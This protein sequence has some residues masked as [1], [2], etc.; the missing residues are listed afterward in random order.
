MIDSNDDHLCVKSGAD[1][2]GRHAA[3]PSENVLFED[4]EVR[5]VSSPSFWGYGVVPV[6]V[7]GVGRG[8][9]GA[10]GA[11]GAWGEGVVARGLRED[12]P[13]T[14]AHA[15]ALWF[16]PLQVR[17]GHGM[18]IGSEMSGGARNITYRNIFYNQKASSSTAYPVFLT[19]ASFWR[20]LPHF[21]ALLPP[22][23]RRTVCYS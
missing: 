23:T 22:H 18:T 21:S 13:W 8:G 15:L 1:W 11:W 9:T 19:W 20:F 6:T 12:R 10:W 3:V 14:L 17:S 16:T 2:L 4:C 5:G 7:A